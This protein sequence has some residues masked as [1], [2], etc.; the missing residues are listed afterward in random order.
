MNIEEIS[1]TVQDLETQ[2]NKLHAALEK[3]GVNSRGTCDIF[4]REFAV[5]VDAEHKATQFVI[6]N[7]SLPHQRAFHVSWWAFFSSFFSM[8]AGA[9][10]AHAQRCGCLP[11]PRLRP[12]P[13][14]APALCLSLPYA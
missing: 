1:Q 10:P 3:K 2:V 9:C 7:F 6:F 12:A 4:G 11:P 13:A 14:P 5:P 8:F